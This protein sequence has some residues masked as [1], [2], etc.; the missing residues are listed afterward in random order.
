MTKFLIKFSA[1]MILIGASHAPSFAV[2]P[3]KGPSSASE[4]APSLAPSPAN[5]LLDRRIPCSAT[6]IPCYR[7]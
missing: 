2:E 5:S 6:G 7:G 3:G 1:L 4:I